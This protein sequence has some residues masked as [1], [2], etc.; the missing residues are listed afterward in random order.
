VHPILFHI[1]PLPVR[2][3]GTLILIGFLVALR[4]VLAAARRRAT[5]DAGNS[6]PT[7][8][9]PITADHVLDMSLVGLVIGIIGTRIVFV[10]LHWDLFRE[11][12]LD[13]LKIWTGGLS[14]IGGP[15]F[16]F[17]YVWWYCRRHQL[18]F[19]AVADIGSP[20]FAL[21]YAFGRIGCFLNGCCYGH[22]C[23]LPWAVR[24]HA[25]GAP[26]ALTAPSHP[27]QLYASAMSLAIFAVLH[28][29]L[30]RPHRDG[31]VTLAYF[32]LYAAYRFVNDFFRSGATSKM[33]LPGL[34]DGQVAALVAIPVLLF[35]LFRLKARP[36]SP[37]IRQS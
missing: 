27:T 15:L 5:E 11:T 2:A 33:V 25:D 13:A 3:Y 7:G 37:V 19:R 10:A 32:A 18:S 4:Y 24:F 26:G 21:A 6:A 28:R 1:G 23:S 22:V 31:A 17:A 9:E 14:F 36:E 34:T 20:G 35:L 16:G 12:P 29:M 30:R 8:F